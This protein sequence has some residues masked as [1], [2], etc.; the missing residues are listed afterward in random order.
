M[1]SQTVTVALTTDQGATPLTSRAFAAA[2]GYQWA[3]LTWQGAFT[4]A[5]GLQIKFAGAGVL[6]L[7]QV[8]VY[9]VA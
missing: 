2:D 3:Q 7:D 4:S 6:W 8:E 1:R 5:G 9:A